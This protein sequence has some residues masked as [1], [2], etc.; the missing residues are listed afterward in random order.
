M[1][2]NPEFS[3]IMKLPS[4]GRERTQGKKW[5]HHCSGAEL[6]PGTMMGWLVWQAVGTKRRCNHSWRLYRRQRA[7]EKQPPFS[8]LFLVS[9]PLLLPRPSAGQ[10]APHQLAWMPRKCLQRRVEEEDRGK[11]YPG[12]K[13]KGWHEKGMISSQRKELCFFMWHRVQKFFISKKESVSQESVSPHENQAV[14]SE[15]GGGLCSWCSLRA[16]ALRIESGIDNEASCHR[17]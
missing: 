17:P 9:Q 6:P 5:Q 15:T 12:M 7:K 3:N 11:T 14:M 13:P 16:L 2:N 8:F 10:R 1:V 4:P